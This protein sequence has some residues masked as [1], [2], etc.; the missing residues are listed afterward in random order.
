MQ[1]A[2]HYVYA[3]HAGVFEPAFALNDDVRAGQLAGRLF[4]PQAPWQAPRDI[5]FSGN[6]RVMCARTFARVEAGDCIALRAAET[7]LV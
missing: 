3:P 7:S 5:A 2:Q 1:G 6:G 4:D